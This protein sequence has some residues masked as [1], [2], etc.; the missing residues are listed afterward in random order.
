MTKQEKNNY[1]NVTVKAV[2]SCGLV[3]LE[4]LDIIHG[5]NDF[6]VYRYT[7]DN[8]IHRAKI[9]YGVNKT[10]FKSV[11]GTVNFNDCMRI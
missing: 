8:S 7:G 3:G 2:Y 1:K 9:N 6:V 11:I 10:T 4:V 5:I